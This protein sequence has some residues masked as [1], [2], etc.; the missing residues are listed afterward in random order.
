MHQFRAYLWARQHNAAFSAV[1]SSTTW[2]SLC[3]ETPGRPTILSPSARHRFRFRRVRGRSVWLCPHLPGQSRNPS[4]HSEA[5]S[6]AI[7][8]ENWVHG[9]RQASSLP[10]STLVVNPDGAWSRYVVDI[11]VPIGADPRASGIWQRFTHGMKVDQA[12]WRLS[13]LNSFCTPTRFGRRRML[14]RLRWCA[15]GLSTL[16]MIVQALSRA[17]G[18][19]Q[20]IWKRYFAPGLRAA[21]RPC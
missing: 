12:C 13:T 18:Y 17:I 14:G 15:A 10:R 21:R 3:A 9:Q 11:N 4:R 16:K 5:M 1:T 19:L 2:E 20:S 6:A 8:A 7:N